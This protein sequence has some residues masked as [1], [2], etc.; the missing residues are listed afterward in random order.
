VLRDQ[1]AVVNREGMR[2]RYHKLKARGTCTKCGD[3]TPR[4]GKVH[5]EICAAIMRAYYRTEAAN[6]FRVCPMA[7]VV[8]PPRDELDDL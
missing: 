6:D 5:C 8:L 7:G 2:A 4:E 1:H 3:S